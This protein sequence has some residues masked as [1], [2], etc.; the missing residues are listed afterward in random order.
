MSGCVRQVGEQ[1][2]VGAAAEQGRQGEGGCSSR[3]AKI[4]WVI[5]I[6]GSVCIWVN[7]AYL[8]LFVTH[9][10]H[11]KKKKERKRKKKTE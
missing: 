8:Y 11:R 2:A 3:D 10:L 7:T 5:I 9:T 1:T 4:L 6:G